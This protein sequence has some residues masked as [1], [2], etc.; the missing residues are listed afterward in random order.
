M[1]KQKLILDGNSLSLKKIEDFI[2]NE[3]E[4]SISREVIKRITDPR[5]LTDECVKS[6]EVIYGVTTGFGEF[7]NVNIS[8][9]KL[10]QLKHNLTFI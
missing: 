5:R 10:E 8:A 9:S 7:A 3:S 2:E 1:K 4:P 6:G